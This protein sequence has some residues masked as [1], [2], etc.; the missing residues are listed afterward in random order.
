MLAAGFPFLA[1]GTDVGLL[2]AAARQNV[3]FI[4]RLKAQK[5]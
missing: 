1:T 2:E 3:D 5:K 4:R